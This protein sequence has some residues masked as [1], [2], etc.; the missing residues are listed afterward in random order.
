MT[1]HKKMN[2]FSEKSGPSLVLAIAAVLLSLLPGTAQARVIDDVK[3]ARQRDGYKITV[4]FLFDLRYQSHSPHE[5]SREFRVQ[6]RPVNFQSLTDEEID[7]LRERAS[8]SWDYTTG[9]PLE[10]IVFEGGD[11]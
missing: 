7:S 8:L 6:L 5:A 9:I 11:P 1:Q 10:E 2:L 4:D 3:V